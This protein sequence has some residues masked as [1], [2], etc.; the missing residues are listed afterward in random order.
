[1]CLM[2]ETVGVASFATAEN[3]EKLLNDMR[4]E[5]TADAQATFA[6]NLKEAL[7]AQEAQHRKDI[8]NERVRSKFQLEEQERK[9]LLLEVKLEE[10]VENHKESARKSAEDVLLLN[11]E[12][13]QTRN[14][15]TET[16]RKME[17][18]GEHREVRE[19]G[20][21]IRVRSFA[22]F[23]AATIEVA[24]AVLLSVGVLYGVYAA[25]KGASL[26]EFGWSAVVAYA[27]ATVILAII[28]W[29]GWTRMNFRRFI[30]AW[31]ERRLLS[32]FS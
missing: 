24:A 18:E 11:H 25:I 22:V 29:F 3:A 10:A 12:L 5:L 15:L 17:S 13:R 26:A 1:M 19:T 14:L 7:A 6:M 8:E 31:I 20:R 28:G 30:A 4:A 16:I 27:L 21:R 2:R 32:F 23:I 9:S